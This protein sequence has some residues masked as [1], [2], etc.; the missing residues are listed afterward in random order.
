[1]VLLHLHLPKEIVVQYV[2]LTKARAQTLLYFMKKEALSATNN[3][4]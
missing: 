4:P 3:R 1:M 2:D